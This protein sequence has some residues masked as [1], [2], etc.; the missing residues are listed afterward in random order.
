MKITYKFEY[1]SFKAE[2]VFVVDNSK[3][4]PHMAKELLDFFTCDYDEHED[5][6]DELMKKYALIAIKA[7]TAENLNLHG[8]IDYFKKAEG[9]LAIDGSMG[10]ELIEVEKYEFQE[11]LLE[12]ERIE[13]GYDIKKL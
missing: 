9:L 3:F 11:D 5:A 1:D 12:M 13:D 2:A 7:A 6:I 8:V 10:V 4:M